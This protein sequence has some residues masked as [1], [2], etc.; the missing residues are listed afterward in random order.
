MQELGSQ[1]L[2]KTPKLFE[3]L[4]CQ[5]SQSPECLTPEV[6]QRVLKVSGC[7]SLELNPYRDR[8]QV[9]SPSAHRQGRLMDLACRVRVTFI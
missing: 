7:G 5:L 9:P 6:F 1:K 4:C 2:L 3:D 8:E